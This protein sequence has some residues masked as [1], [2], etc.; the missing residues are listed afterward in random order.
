[1]KSRFLLSLFILFAGVS[2]SASSD[3]RHSSSLPDG[4]TERPFYSVYS[5]HWKITMET[6][7]IRMQR[8]EKFQGI[9]TIVNTGKEASW[10]PLDLKAF[11][12]MGIHSINGAPLQGQSVV[13]WLY[14]PPSADAKVLCRIFSAGEKA[15]F[16]RDE[17]APDHA[18]LF[19]LVACFS[20]IHPVRFEVTEA[21]KKEPN[22]VAGGN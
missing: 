10:I 13:T 9:V 15:S 1:M 16:T 11:F 5:Q 22:R 17:I 8:R 3:K 12:Q 14:E 2:Y 7:G 20:A 6:S 4:V 19:E 18:G 21:Q